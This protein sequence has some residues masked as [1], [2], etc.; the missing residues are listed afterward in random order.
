MDATFLGVGV[1]EWIMCQ[2]NQN[3]LITFQW[4]TFNQN[5]LESAVLWSSENK[6]NA[7]YYN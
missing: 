4:N 6:K 5:H 7:K 3:D 1:L 2:H